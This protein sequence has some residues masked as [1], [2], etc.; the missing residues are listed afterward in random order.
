MI[1]IINCTDKD[2]ELL[3][4]M[5]KQLIEDEKANNLMNI[6][7]LENRMKDF[8][9]NGYEAFFFKDD[10]RIIGYALCDMTKEPIY[11]RQFLIN[12]E[13]RR[14]HYGKDAF[15]KLLEKLE[16]KEIEID[17]LKW[18]EI[19]IKFWEKIGFKEQSKRMKYEIIGEKY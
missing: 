18:N 12:R 10:E 13:E 6:F 2:I 19:G 16:V 17:V 14:K 5:N 3:A 11:L 9:N 1:E 8:L 7:Q 15:N 4:K